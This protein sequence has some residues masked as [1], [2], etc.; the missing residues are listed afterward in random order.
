MTQMN[1]RALFLKDDIQTG[2]HIFYINEHTTIPFS[3]TIVDYNK[4]ILI[5]EFEVKNGFKTGIEKVY[6][7]TG[8]LE[9]MNETAHNTID[10]VAK[11]FYKNG[12]LKSQSIV[13]RNVFIN[14]IQY[15][16][17]GEIAE[18]WEISEEN[19]GYTIV[20]DRIAEYKSKCVE[21]R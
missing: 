5:W 8:E 2:E 10:G 15:K 9:E 18:I 1:Y 20:R 6:Y 14:T 19:A 16:E 21:S 17:T 7:P 13:I 11:E 4:G 12:Q 3:G